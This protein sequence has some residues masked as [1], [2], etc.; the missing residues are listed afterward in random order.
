[1]NI[2]QLYGETY[3]E[4]LETNDIKINEHLLFG[5]FSYAGEI[6]DRVLINKIKDNFDS[7]F[8]TWENHLLP[9]GSRGPLCK[10]AYD[11]GVAYT[12]Y[13]YKDYGA[14]IEKRTYIE[15]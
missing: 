3:K 8:S 6:N 2:T 15:N 14:T 7:I 1:M 12:P 9:D 5:L 11:C 13:W 10:F 4:Q